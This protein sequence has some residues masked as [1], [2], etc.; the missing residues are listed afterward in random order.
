MFGSE[1]RSQR[2]FFRFFFSLA[3]CCFSPPISPHLSDAHSTWIAFTDWLG[4]TPN[5][6]IIFLICSQHSVLAQRIIGNPF[7]QLV[8]QELGLYTA[9]VA[10]W[11]PSGRVSPHLEGEKG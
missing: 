2:G 6:W 3:A 11:T 8:R 10:S 7:A 5:S 9:G 4:T 1:S